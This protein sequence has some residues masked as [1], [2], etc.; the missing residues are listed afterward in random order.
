MFTGGARSASVRRA[1]SELDAARGDL[2]AVRLEV[3]QEIDAA[4]TAVLEADARMQAL[5]AAVAQW[6]EVARIE[7]LALE[8][9]SGEQRDL[10]RAQA[11]L[12]QAR[13]GQ[14]RARQDAILARVQLARAEGVLTRTWVS[15]SLED[16]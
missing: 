1:A 9:G 8:A 2:G 11:G 12:F 6:E 14:A 15:E 16:R 13:A 4:V 10:L 3:A 5:G 7:V